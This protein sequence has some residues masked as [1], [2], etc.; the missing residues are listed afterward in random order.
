MAWL[1]NFRIVWKVAIIV[2]ILGIGELLFY[3]FRGP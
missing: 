3:R 1:N 2:A